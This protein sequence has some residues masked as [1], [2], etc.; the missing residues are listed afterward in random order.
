VNEWSKIQFTD[1]GMRI[2]TSFLSQR[3][4]AS[5]FWA[6]AFLFKKETAGAEHGYKQK[7]GQG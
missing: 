7:K 1:Y 6:V 5:K 3:F 4:I 2:L